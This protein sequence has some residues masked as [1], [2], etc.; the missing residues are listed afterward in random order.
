MT[1]IV[2]KHKGREGLLMPILQEINAAYNYLPEN[3]L[4]YVS[5]ETNTPLTHILRMATF[6]SAFSMTPRG[7]HIINVCTGT[8]CYVKGSERLMERFGDLLGIK[9]EETT[10]DMKFTLKGVRCIG[11]CGLAPAATV[12]DVVYGKLTTAQV[13]DIVNR[14]KEA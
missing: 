12:G 7:K 14:Y 10:K 1:E 3:T 6:Y 9:P 13:P 8:T 11:C 2:E 5:Q 4:R